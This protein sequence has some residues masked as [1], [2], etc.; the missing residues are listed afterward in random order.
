MNDRDWLDR[1]LRGDALN[2]TDLA[3]QTGHGERYISKILPLAFLAPDARTTVGIY[4]GL[5]SKE[6]TSLTCKNHRFARTSFL[7]VRIFIDHVPIES[8]KAGDF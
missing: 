2:Q 5:K 1:I 3:K 8:Q 6:L 7:Q 4:D